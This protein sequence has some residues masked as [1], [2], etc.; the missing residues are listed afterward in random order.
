[1]GSDEMRRR[2]EAHPALATP[3]R[4]IFVSRSAEEVDRVVRAE[5]H[6]HRELILLQLTYLSELAGA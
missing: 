2:K 4:E 1:M 5:W 6:P 3:L